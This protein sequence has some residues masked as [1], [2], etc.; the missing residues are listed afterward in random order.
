MNL[1]V[2]MAANY[3]IA[4][5]RNFVCSFKRHQQNAIL[6]LMLQNT[7]QETRDWLQAKDVLTADVGM[8]GLHSKFA[9]YY[10]LFDLLD[11]T[12]EFTRI[13]HCDVRDAVAQADIFAQI[14]GPGLHIFLEEPTLPIG[15]SSINST[16]IRN[17]YDEETLA[18]YAD[19][20]IVCSGTTLGDRESFLV[21][22]KAM[23]N[24]FQRLLTL[25]YPDLTLR[26][27]DQ[28]MHIHLVYSGEL[29]AQLTRTGKDLVFHKNGDGVFTLGEAR[30]FL[31]NKNRQVCTAD[32]TLPA[33]VHQ[34]DRIESLR[35]M[36][37]DMYADG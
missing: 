36:F 8:D 5:L 20:T 14:P 4:E 26:H 29:S 33:V 12:P 27:G 31:I 9:R 19:K 35:E 3:G 23:A 28:V 10:A 18:R 32:K 2:A 24:E 13:F 15:K 11:S 16:W 6:L 21:Y 30:E 34:Y 17:A 22:T 1:V 37:D 7:N 25:K